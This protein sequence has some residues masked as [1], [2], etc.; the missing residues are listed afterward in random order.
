MGRPAYR[1][2][3]GVVFLLVV[4]YSSSDKVVG[5]LLGVIGLGDSSITRVAVILTDIAILGV[6]A[7]LKRA[8]GRADG[9]PGRLWRWWSAAAVAVVVVDVVRAVVGADTSLALDLAC[10]GTF[11][12]AMALLLMTSLNAHPRILFSTAARATMPLDWQRVG[13][14]APLII[15]SVAAYFGATLWTDS[16]NPEAVRHLSAGLQEE[17][18]QMSPVDQSTTLAQLCDDGVNPTYFQHIA[19][20]IPVLLLALGVEFN[21]FRQ[22]VRD[23]VQRAVMAVTVTVMCVALVL[24]VSTLPWDGAGCDDVLQPWHEYL[25]FTVSLQAIF[26]ALTTVVWML[27]ATLS[28]DDELPRLDSNQEPSD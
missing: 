28:S 24:A 14:T 12:L 16:L 8:I 22:A 21:Y 11:L 3:L 1:D 4:A 20:V 5:G 15:G 19:E 10:S 18:A 26:M 27:L 6:T 23:P 9:T 25:A 7:V 13:A 2:V 17:I